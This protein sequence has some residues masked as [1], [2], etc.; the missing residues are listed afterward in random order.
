MCKLFFLLLALPVVS[1]A[2][3]TEWDIA[4]Q[5]AFPPGLGMRIHMPPRDYNPHFKFEND[6]PAY[7]QSR[8]YVVREDSIYR[9]FFW[10]Y[11]YTKD[12]LEKKRNP[13]LNRYDYHWMKTH[14]LDS[15]PVIDFSKNELVMF[16][17]CAQCLAHCEHGDGNRGSCHRNACHYREAW[18]MRKK[19]NA[20]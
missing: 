16:A 5:K 13:P 6:A 20:G 2:Q 3:R 17:A 15:L 19:T 7:G 8:I 4:F 1:T 12:S 9:K 11:T 10:R 14:L 18:F